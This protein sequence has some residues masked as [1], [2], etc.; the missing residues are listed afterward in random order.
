MLQIIIGLIAYIALGIYSEVDETAKAKK[1]RM[2]D[3]IDWNEY[4]ANI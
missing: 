1:Q 3:S 2:Y 4:Y